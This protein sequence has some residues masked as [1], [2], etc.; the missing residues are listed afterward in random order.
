MNKTVLDIEAN[1]DGDILELKFSAFDDEFKSIAQRAHV[2]AGKKNLGELSETRDGQFYKKINLNEL[3]D[4]H[5]H[6][7]L[8][9]KNIV[10]TEKMILANKEE[11]GEKVYVKIPTEQTRNA[12]LALK[13]KYSNHDFARPT[14]IK[15]F[16][17]QDN[18]VSVRTTQDKNKL[19]VSIVPQ[20]EGGQE[21]ELKY[22]YSE[23]NK[24]ENEKKYITL[25]E[26]KSETY[27]ESAFAMF[28]KY[29]KE[30]PDYRFVLSKVNPDF[31][32]LKEKF[33]DQLIAKGSKEYFDVILHTKLLVS[34]EFPAHVI[35]DKCIDYEIIDYIYKLP[36][37]FLQHGITFTKPIKTPLRRTIWKTG[38]TYNVKKIVVSSE[39]EK[40]Q[41]FNIGYVEEDLIKTGMT[42][43]DVINR[44]ME[45]N[46]IVYMPTFRPWEEYMVT[47]GKLQ[48]TTYYKD[49]MNVINSFRKIG[50]V[51]DLIIVPHP[52][53]TEFFTPIAD[54]LGCEFI[55]SYT[56]IRD[57][58]KLFITDFSSAAYD[59]QYRGAYVIYLWNRKEE[60]IENY[61]G[62][63][64]HDVGNTSGPIVNT[65]EELEFEAIIAQKTGYKLDEYYQKN[66]KRILEFD[67]GKNTERIYDEIN[68]LLIEMDAED[69]S[70]DE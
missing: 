40:E 1:L 42:T 30:N 45:K 65:M 15:K 34:S 46:K 61:K 56:D 9:Y 27:G 63:T 38:A 68:K 44:D 17:W 13:Y 60:I 19:M 64:P 33:G 8:K 67:D 29:Y 69:K 37:V 6:I 39:L 4:F 32:M 70:G 14:T 66:F 21:E 58:I 43:L 5:T 48:E 23:L 22:F 16:T 11:V 36:Y 2:C 51:E 7:H 55:S 52:K 31:E 20:Y 53:F 18:F 59:A 3:I 57:N 35:S 62:E 41:F 50:Q 47:S 26:K 12:K 24:Q 10:K 54:Q 25:F 28:E 49:I